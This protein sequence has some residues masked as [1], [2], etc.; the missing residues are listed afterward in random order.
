MRKG[1]L[2]TI[3][4]MFLLMGCGSKD[5]AVISAEDA[6][7]KIDNKESMVLVIGSSTCHA[8]T[9]FEPVIE[10]VVKNYPDLPIMKVYIDDEDPIT[11]EGETEQVRVHFKELETRTTRMPS[12]PTTLFI[13]DGIL[14][15]NLVGTKEYAKVK[16]KLESSGFIS[17]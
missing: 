3:C 9:S 8:C 13:K 4:C 15:D 10:E 5:V 6:V 2:L 12:T 7:K 11:V 16:T 1:I 17:K 14:V